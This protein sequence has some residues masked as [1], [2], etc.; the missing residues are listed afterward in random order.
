MI[1]WSPQ[2]SVGVKIIDEQHK[3]FLDAFNELYDAFFRGE[4]KEK[5]AITL[6]KI[7]DYTEFHFAT[8]EKYFREFNY[9]GAEEHIR[10]HDD[11][12]AQLVEF[13]KHFFQEDDL[14]KLA[15]DLVDMLE[16][17]LVQHLHGMDQKYVA[18]F[19]EHGLK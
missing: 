3:E 16:N 11:F 9:A 15:E 10:Q 7:S 13:K 5:L 12:R 18:C 14:E 19:K 17:W 6:K 1:N 2:Y 8:E 4:A